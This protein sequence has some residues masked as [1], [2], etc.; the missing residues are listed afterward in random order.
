[1][2]HQAIVDAV[3]HPHRHMIDL[4]DVRIAVHEWGRA[5]RGPL[6]SILLVHATGF[7]GRCWDRI[8][9]DL[10]ARHVVAIDQRGHGAS[11]MA[12]FEDW[13][14]MGNDLAAAARYLGLS[15]AYGVGHSM[16]GAA[17]LL[18][19]QAAPECLAALTLIDP[20]ILPPDIYA[21]GVNPMAAPPGAENPIMRRFDDFK[22]PADMQARLA[23][24]L[25]Y[26]LFDPAVLADYCRHGLLAGPGTGRWRLA[27][28]PVNEA[29]V[30]ETA[31]C[32]DPHL[33]L[34]DIRQPVTV[35]RAMQPETPDHFRSFL[36]SPTDPALARQLP[37]GRDWLLEQFTHFLP[38][39]DP[40][41]CARLILAA[42][43]ATGGADDH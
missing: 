6:P 8:V 40:G 31:L 3:S 41:F 32:H 21:R 10:G 5:H 42:E 37:A 11:G 28:R 26:R 7:H 13:R 15:G 36:Y 27:C 39:Q 24:R 16:G 9:T 19:A 14:A 1:M 18:A 12:A 22:G 20:V 23:D 29:S 43:P 35:A 4:P 25:P 17:L 34:P 30:Y 2:T 38:M 33:A